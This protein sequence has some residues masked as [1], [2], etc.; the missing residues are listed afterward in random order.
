MYDPQSWLVFMGWWL[1][2]P[3]WIPYPELQTTGNQGSGNTPAWWLGSGVASGIVGDWSITP[4][5]NIV[6]PWNMAW[7]RIYKTYHFT[8]RGFGRSFGRFDDVSNHWF[9]PSLLVVSIASPVLGGSSLFLLVKTIHVSSTE[10]IQ[11]QSVWNLRKTRK[12]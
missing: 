11:N 5:Q 4:V 1:W 9:L 3:G 2:Q 8:I 7:N 6:K 10:I 12:T